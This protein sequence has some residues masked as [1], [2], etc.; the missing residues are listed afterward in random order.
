[1]TEGR[2]DPIAL[3]KAFIARVEEVL[4]SRDPEEVE[5]LLK[6]VEQGGPASTTKDL[7]RLLVAC[8]EPTKEEQ[9][10]AERLKWK[11]AELARIQTEKEERETAE[12][13]AWLKVERERMHKEDET[14][15]ARALAMAV[16]MRAKERVGADA[17]VQTVLVEG[18]NPRTKKN[19]TEIEVYATDTCDMVFRRVVEACGIV[20]GNNVFLSMDGEESLW[21]NQTNFLMRWTAVRNPR[22]L[23]AF[24]VI[25]IPVKYPMLEKPSNVAITE[26][27]TGEDIART[28]S[29]MFRREVPYTP[30][31]GDTVVE[32]DES[33][34]KA[35]LA[36]QR[37]CPPQQKAHLT[38]KV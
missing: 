26:G 33:V 15:H 6:W 28:A 29:R 3:L 36:Y 37:T 11:Q 21:G 5:T 18:Y 14:I 16:A 9:E 19:S 30:M 24:V 31:F 25:Y 32:E 2:N 8:R 34:Y 7:T 23:I 27:T 20:D 10:A 1:M 12:R 4:Q 17:K 13:Q 35:Y 38:F 22:L